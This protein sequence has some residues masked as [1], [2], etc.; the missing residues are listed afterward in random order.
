MQFDFYVKVIDNYG[1]VGFALSLAFSLY[2]KVKELKI[3]FYCSDSNVCEL[4]LWNQQYHFLKIKKLDKLYNAEKFEWENVIPSSYI[5][6][7]FKNPLPIDYLRSYNFSKTI[8]NFDY[9]TFDW[10]F[11][12]FHLQDHYQSD[13]LHKIIHYVPWCVGLMG[14]VIVSQSK[15]SN[16]LSDLSS[17][18][19]IVNKPSI[20]IF[21]YEKSIAPLLSY[22]DSY[23]GML[24]VC[25]YKS[26]QTF[27]N[28]ESPY[29]VNVP[30]L[31]IQEYGSLLAGCD[32]NFVRWENSVIES[33]VH[34]KPTIWDIYKEENDYHLEKL[35]HYLNFVE[36]FFDNTDLFQNYKDLI[37]NFN[38]NIDFT[39]NFEILVKDIKSYEIVFKKIS[40]HIK[41]SYDLT[42][43]I[44]KILNL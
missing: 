10:W 43:K 18:V 38:T 13:S 33:L 41:N 3:N 37:I 42:E 40:E 22:L 34:G 26:Q 28:F 15:N 5:F 44:Q 9:L 14:W 6:N 4:L 25:G 11:V 31:H 23:Q 24:Y 27:K 16:D 29:L 30:F 1:D 35:A 17:L 2:E 12:D 21:T 7:F 39:E 32:I 19:D 36:K 20:S 8:I